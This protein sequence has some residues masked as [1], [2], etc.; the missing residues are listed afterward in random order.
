MK[1]S[2]IQKFRSKGSQL[3]ESQWEA[4]L[5]TIFL[6]RPLSESIEKSDSLETLE[7]NATITGDQL[8]III[9]KN[10][11]GITRRLG[12]ISL[13][14]D[15]SQEIDS[16]SWAATAVGRSSALEKEAED[17]RSKYDAQ[18][19]T[20]KRLN[21]QLEQFIEA[22]EQHENALFEKFAVLLNEKKSKIRNLLRL[23]KRAGIDAQKGIKKFP[24]Y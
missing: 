18:S 2:R 6:R 16:I 19:E 20:L 8:V 10:I 21:Q 9:R 17:L 12:E 13:N 22:K 1:Q 24:Y 11:S 4:I 14:K 5:H 7:A 3:D 15:D 23:L